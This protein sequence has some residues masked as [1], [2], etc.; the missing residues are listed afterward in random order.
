VETV[1]V[2]RNTVFL[3]LSEQPSL[4]PRIAIYNSHPPPRYNSRKGKIYTS[5]YFRNY[6]L[7]QFSFRLQQ[8]ATIY[9]SAVSVIIGHGYAY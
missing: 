1:P 4:L 5:T 3:L 7:T 9:S 8:S 6:E 2:I